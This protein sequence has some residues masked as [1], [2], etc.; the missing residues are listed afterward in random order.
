MKRENKKSYGEYVDSN[1]NSHRIL[2]RVHPKQCDAFYKAQEK[3]DAFAMHYLSLPYWEK[4]PYMIQFELK[5]IELRCELDRELAKPK[6]LIE[7]EMRV[8]Y[9]SRK[10]S[11]TPKNRFLFIPF[12]FNCRQR[13]R[14]WR[15]RM[16]A[17]R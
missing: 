16:G 15:R 7:L 17:K 9:G 2:K 10:T 1:G 5:M 12:F 14:A 11:D 13:F 8:K 6:E 3:E 4:P